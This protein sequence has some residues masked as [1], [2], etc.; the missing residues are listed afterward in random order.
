MSRKFSG[1]KGMS[2][3]LPDTSAIWQRLEAT[4]HALMKDY[5]FLEIRTPIV[6]EAGLF[7]HGVGEE[8]EVVQKQMY[9]FEDKGGR[10]LTLRPEGTAPAARAY[11]EHGFAQTESLTRWYYLGPMFRYERMKAGRYRQFSQL[12]VE[13]Y[14]SADASQDVEVIALAHELLKRLGIPDVVLHLNSLGD[15]DARAAYAAALRQ[16]FESSRA[17]MSE[18]ARAAL[19]R[20]PL[21]LLD[22]KEPTLAHLIAQAPELTAYLSEPSLRHFGEVQALLE[23]VGVPYRIDTKLVRGLDYYTRTAFEFVYEPESEAH[24]LGTA[25]TVCG[26]GRYDGLVRALGGPEKPAVG[27]AAGLDRLVLLMRTMPLGEAPRPLLVLGYLD[28]ASRDA[29]VVLATQLRNDHIRADFA[30]PGKL[31]KQVERAHKAGAHYFVALGEA[32][33]TAGAAEVKDLRSGE[34]AANVRLTELVQWL[35]SHS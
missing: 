29:A 22:S 7:I 25:G 8:T 33:L 28:A 15:P 20:N 26:G 19:E 21:R 17:G 30:M 12:G 1:V 18:D 13:A 24:A 2:D 10:A 4:A 23:K 3:V 35:Q 11:I 32:E 34:R 9:T 27:F 31:G 16:H 6:E 5:G 14:G